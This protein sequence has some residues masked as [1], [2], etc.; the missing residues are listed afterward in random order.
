MAIVR[1]ALTET[2]NAYKDMPD[3]IA[4]LGR[5][6]GRLDDIRAANVAHNISLIKA[7][8]KAGAQVIGLGELCTAPYFALTKD[9]MWLAMAED[10][11]RGPSVTALAE[12]AAASGIIVVAPLYE[13]D[14]E[15]G[16]RFNTA[17]VIDETGALLGKY[18]KTHIPC[19]A[20]E[21]GEFAE[22]FYY[23]RSEGPQNHASPHILGTNPYFPVFKTSVGN[24]AVAICYD[25]HFEGV[26]SALA[27]GGAQI[28]F[29]PAV[30][31]G[32]K[33]RRL[34]DKEFFIDACR[35]HLFIGGS[36]RHGEALEP[37]LLRRQP[38]RRPRRQQ[39]PGP[40]QELG[41]DHRRPG[42]GHPHRPR[43]VGLGP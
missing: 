30:T 5:L 37:V 22:T 43:S 41:A 20:N 11:E 15:T 17:V 38:L 10:V 25:R 18:R 36:N 40:L 23:G 8:A 27:A 32:A 6:E 7:A 35:H 33:S 39:G 3:K 28:V 21:L 2:I 9:P 1:A 31:F 24:I 14:A 19:G 34:W 16:R 12:A 4:G 13:L 29:S 42:P 26:I